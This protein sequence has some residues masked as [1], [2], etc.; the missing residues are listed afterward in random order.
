MTTFQSS[1]VNIY[2]VGTNEIW[3]KKMIGIRN[4]IDWLDQI[5]QSTTTNRHDNQFSSK[6]INL[7]T[8][9]IIS[10]GRRV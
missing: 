1:P 10:R 4:E 5:S 3:K 7:V 8:E 9:L 6:S 2:C